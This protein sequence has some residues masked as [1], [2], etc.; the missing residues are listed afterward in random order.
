MKRA[1]IAILLLATNFIVARG[2]APT[3]DHQ[4]VI[5]DFISNVKQQNKEALAAKV[6]FPLKRDAPIPPIKSKQEFLERYNEIFDQALTTTIVSSQP[7]KN[8]TAMGWRG[9]MLDNGKV[10]LD[11]DGKLIA[12]NYQSTMEKRKQSALIAGDKKQ[13]Y[14]TVNQYRKPVYLLETKKF[15]IRIDEIG[16]DNF[17]Y[18]SWGL[19]RSMREAPD[20][21]IENGT[22]FFE[23]TGGNHRYEFKNDGYLYECSFTVLGVDDKNPAVLKIYKDGKELLSQPATIIR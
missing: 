14:K 20:L 3:A 1:F 16:E 7:G 8:W 12:V 13:L 21:V 18:S 15:R 11:E 19:Q 6:R 10:W 4:K 5:A 17:R 22:A 23:G 2:Q 9:I